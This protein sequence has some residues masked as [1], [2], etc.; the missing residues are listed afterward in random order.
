VDLPDSPNPA[1]ALEAVAA[2]PLAERPE[3]LMQL[4]D[5]LERRLDSTASPGGGPLEQPPG[6]P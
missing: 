6:R 3:A 2:L 5:E 1:A 4:A